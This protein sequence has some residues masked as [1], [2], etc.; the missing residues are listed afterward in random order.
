MYGNR[1]VPTFLPIFKKP[2]LAEEMSPISRGKPYFEDLEPEYEGENR[3]AKIPA[4]LIYLRHLCEFVD[5]QV[6][7]S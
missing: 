5:Q 3:R 6:N 7:R 1:G 2:Q 4:D